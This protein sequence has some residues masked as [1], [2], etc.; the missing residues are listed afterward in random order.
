MRISLSNFIIIF[1]FITHVIGEPRLKGRSLLEDATA[2][3]GA[4]IRTSENSVSMSRD[5]YG[6]TALLPGEVLVN[7]FPVT[8]C[9]A[10]PKSKKRWERGEEPCQA[11]G[12][13]Q[14]SVCSARTNKTSEG[15]EGTGCTLIE[16]S[17]EAVSF[18]SYLIYIHNTYLE[19]ACY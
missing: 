16:T 9:G 8:E 11:T 18:T 17:R 6:I 14:I 7:C 3:I 19:I 15:C 13:K 10:C 5:K 1:F 2:V 4:E 12:F